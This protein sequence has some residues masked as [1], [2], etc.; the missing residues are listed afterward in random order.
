MLVILL[1]LLIIPSSRQI[2]GAHP[3]P[4]R[5][6]PRDGTSEAPGLWGVNWGQ[7]DL[8]S[9]KQEFDMFLPFTSSIKYGGLTWSDIWS[10]W[11]CEIGGMTRS[12][13]HRCPRNRCMLVSIKVPPSSKHPRS[14]WKGYERW[15]DQTKPAMA[16]VLILNVLCVFISWGKEMTPKLS[17]LW[18]YQKLGDALTPQSP[19]LCQQ[20]IQ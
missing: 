1:I 11:E 7:H 19:K 4:W 8:W 13:I 15:K 2:N 12:F 6:A 5:W 17:F 10:F 14:G 16:R 9:L 3:A 20:L 18:S